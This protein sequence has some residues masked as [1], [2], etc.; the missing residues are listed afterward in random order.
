MQ[1]N[2]LPDTG[3]GGNVLSDSFAYR[4]GLQ[5][6]KSGTIFLFPDG[7]MERSLG[8]TWLFLSFKDN[9]GKGSY[10]DFE[11]MR[12]CQQ[13]AI[14]GH[15]FLFENRIYS[16]ELHPLVDEILLASVGFNLVTFLKNKGMITFSRSIGCT[17]TG[18][19]RS[20]PF[21]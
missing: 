2:A 13:E 14:V 16:D 20:C 3:A 12:G 18:Y 7:T 9:P 10:V 6:E 11:V 1:I 8:R 15:D 4:K 19:A 21:A 5:L 17:N